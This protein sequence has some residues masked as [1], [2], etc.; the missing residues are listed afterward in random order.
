MSAGNYC[1]IITALVVI[2]SFALNVSAQSSSQKEAFCTDQGGTVKNFHLYN[3][4][5]PEYKPV[6]LKIAGPLQVTKNNNAE[7]L[8][9]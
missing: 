4:N 8:D 9:S 5:T 3:G 7:L 6:G 2:S 1:L